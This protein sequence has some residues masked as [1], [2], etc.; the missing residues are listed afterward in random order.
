MVRQRDFDPVGVSR[1]GYFQMRV[2]SGQMFKGFLAS[3]DDCLLHLHDRLDSE[4]G[5]I[6]E[7]TSRAADSRRQSLIGV[8]LQFNDF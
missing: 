3:G 8:D 1:Q 4:P 5:R 7:V 2:I 6:G